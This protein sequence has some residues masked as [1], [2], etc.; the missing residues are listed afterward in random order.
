[1]RHQIWHLLFVPQPLSLLN[2]CLWNQEPT[3]SGQVRMRTKWFANMLYSIVGGCTW[4]KVLPIHVF[5]SQTVLF[6]KV[7]PYPIRMTAL[8][9]RIVV[10][11]T[12]SGQVSL[13]TFYDLQEDGHASRY[14]PPV[15]DLMVLISVAC[16]SVEQEIVR[17]LRVVMYGRNVRG[18]YH[19][20]FYRST[21]P[22]T[23]K[24]L[25]TIRK[26]TS[27][28]FSNWDFPPWTL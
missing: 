1:M 6:M 10:D 22:L 14:G 12:Y 19:S 25:R 28:Q 18:R 3:R 7:S 15:L 5:F 21:S 27:S 11:V 8:F 17:Q 24:N 16:V 2:S 23:W 20:R 9:L 26:R 4:Y 13:W